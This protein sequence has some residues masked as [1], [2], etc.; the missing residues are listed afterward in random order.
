MG[1]INRREVIHR[2]ESLAEFMDYADGPTDMTGYRSSRADSA[3][4][5]GSETW[6]EAKAQAFTWTTGVESIKVAR[7]KIDTVDIE[8]IRKRSMDRGTINIGEALIGLPDC[9]RTRVKVEST[10]DNSGGFVDIVLNATVSGAIDG[11]VIATR[12]AA[13]L[14]LSDALETAGKQTRITVVS[15]N[16]GADRRHYG[17]WAVVVKHPGRKAS[18]ASYAWA[19]ANPGFLRRAVFS[20][21]ERMDRVTR[22]AFNVPGGYGSVIDIPKDRFPGAI[23]VQG[24][25]YG[26]HQWSSAESARAWVDTTLKSQGID[27]A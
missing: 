21:M 19:V 9:R 17:E 20:A 4:W 10:E 5:Y 2:F 16:G 15:A 7:A 6:E 8:T 22:K 27:V 26:G 14:A 11:D 3:K 24:A 13:V 12:G 18:M 1:K 23:V 25:L